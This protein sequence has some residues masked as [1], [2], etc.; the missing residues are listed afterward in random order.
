MVQTDSSLPEYGTVAYFYEHDS[1]P[2]ISSCVPVSYNVGTTYILNRWRYIYMKLSYIYIYTYIH[3]NILFV[4]SELKLEILC[5][6]Q[7]AVSVFES[8]WHLNPEHHQQ[9]VHL[10]KIYKTVISPLFCMNVNVQ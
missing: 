3:R 6:L 9:T 5:F 7:Y 10:T 2:L 4:S 8:T 1:K